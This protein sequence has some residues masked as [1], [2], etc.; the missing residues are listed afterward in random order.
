MIIGFSSLSKVRF[1][2]RFS[3][4]V[5]F[6][7]QAPSPQGVKET[8]KMKI[9]ICSR[10]VWTCNNLTICVISVIICVNPI[11]I[12]TKQDSPE[13]GGYR[14]RQGRALPGCFVYYAQWLKSHQVFQE[15]KNISWIEIS[16]YKGLFFHVPPYRRCLLLL[17]T[18]WN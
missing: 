13:A 1:F 14:A 11:K 16:G 18:Y 17:L 15:N 12:T 10:P 8:R 4:F 5:G 7:P 9:A 6:K 2:P 3:I